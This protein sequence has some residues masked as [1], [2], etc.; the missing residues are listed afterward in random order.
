MLGMSTH[1]ASSNPGGA[2]C[3][4][5]R[6]AEKKPADRSAGFLVTIALSC[7]VGADLR[8]RCLGDHAIGQQAFNR[9]PGLLLLAGVMVGEPR[10]RRNQPADDDVLLQA[11]QL[12]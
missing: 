3:S 7:R 9:A 2:G 1:P 8:C 10:P 11:T 6:L 12:V 4:A 5:G